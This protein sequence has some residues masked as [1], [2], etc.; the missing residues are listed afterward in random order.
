MKEKVT[1]Y[2]I[3]SK[4]GISPSTVSR[5]LNN[6]SLVEDEKRK[7][8]LRA[9]EGMAYE[10]RTIRKQ[11][12]RAI[13]NIRLLLPAV[14]YD[15][16]HFF[17]DVSD[18]IKGIEDGFGDTRI[19]IIASINDGDPG[20]FNS[21]KLGVIDGCIFAFTEPS[22]LLE[23]LLK[24]REIPFILL[25]RE[26]RKNSFVKVDSGKSMGFLAD[27]MWKRRG[28]RMRPCYIG[29]SPLKQV[30]RLR[31]KAVIRACAERDIPV[32]PGDILYVESFADVRKEVMDRIISSRYNAVL[33]FNDILAISLYQEAVRRR[34]SI[35][36]DFSLS[37]FDNSPIQEMLDRR[38]DTVEFSVRRLGHE[39]GLWLHQWIIEKKHVPVRKSIEGP[40]VKGETI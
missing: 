16:I 38:I 15:Y 28:N 2:D 1:V 24:E 14:K 30:S 7:L 40:Y 17:Y 39:A 32:R 21:K 29:F 19:N 20:V 5:A 22:S 34:I 13:I 25:N 26:A 27:E 35:P 31:E 4:L 12:G 3:A 10:K 9:A 6:S 18:L 33:C 8:I 11:R 36:A 37:G 23:A